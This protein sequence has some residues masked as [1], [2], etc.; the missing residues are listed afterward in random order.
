MALKTEGGLAQK[1]QAA[2]L[3]TPG[4]MAIRFPFDGFVSDFTDLG[5]KTT[6][7]TLAE[8]MGRHFENHLPNVLEPKRL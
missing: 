6:P 2:F 7:F 5:H 8:G 3:V 4:F 1:L